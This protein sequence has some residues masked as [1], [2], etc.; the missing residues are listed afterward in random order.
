MPEVARG[1]AFAASAGLLVYP[2]IAE[3]EQ[4]LAPQ[5]MTEMRMTGTGYLARVGQWFK[6]SF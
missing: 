2:Q 1:P 3:H 5:Q 6:E 4:L